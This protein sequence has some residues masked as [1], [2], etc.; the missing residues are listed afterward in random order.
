M[1]VHTTKEIFNVTFQNH[2]LLPAEVCYAAG[3]YCKAQEANDVLKVLIDHQ[4]DVNEDSASLKYTIL[5][6]TVQKG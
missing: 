2:W 1:Q 4:V 5:H 3:R 6:Y